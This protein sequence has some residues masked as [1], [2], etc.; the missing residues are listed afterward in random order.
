MKIHIFGASGS[1]VSTLG[2]ALSERLDLPYFDSDEYFW[3]RSDPP[4]TVKR[5]AAARNALLKEDLAKQ[6]GASSPQWILGGS[7]VNWNDPVFRDFDLAVF[8][9]I[10]PGVRI[11]RLQQRE[12]ERYGDVLFLDPERRRLYEAF[13]DWASGYD[14]NSLSGRTLAAHEKWMRELDCPVLELR[15]D[16]STEERVEAIIDYIIRSKL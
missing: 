15:E 2:R 9:W 10:P 14:D 12:Q 5:R 1:G 8:L 6:G 4:F 13:I 3:E 11:R 7:V 16:I